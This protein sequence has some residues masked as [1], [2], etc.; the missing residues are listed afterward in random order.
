M[1]YNPMQQIYLLSVTSKL[2]AFN[3]TIPIESTP[4][5]RIAFEDSPV[6]SSGATVTINNDANGQKLNIPILPSHEYIFAI[7]F[8]QS[9]IVHSCDRSN[10]STQNR[11]TLNVNVTANETPFDASQILQSTL[12][13]G[14]KSF[15]SFKNQFSSLMSTP[16]FRHVLYYLAFFLFFLAYLL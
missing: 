15:T 12:E 14:S 11:T 4:E 3:Q 9:R 5:H 1:L 8:F 16:L 7:F 2:M 13:L 6:P 10:D